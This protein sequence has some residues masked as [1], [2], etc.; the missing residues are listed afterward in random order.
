MNVSTNNR[1]K[2]DT[3]LDTMSGVGYHLVRSK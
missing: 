1:K 2:K 3:I